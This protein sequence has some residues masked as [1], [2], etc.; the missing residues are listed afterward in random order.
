MTEIFIAENL[1]F[2]S[3]VDKAVKLAFMNPNSNTL[4]PLIHNNGVID[5]LKQI[6]VVAID[7][8]DKA[9]SNKLI[10]R[11]HGVTK[12]AYEKAKLKGFEIIDATCPKVREVYDIIENFDS[13][14]YLVAIIGNKDHPEIIGLASRVDGA[15]IVN[16]IEEVK[17][18]KK[19]DKIC[20]VSQTTNSKEKF[21]LISDKLKEKCNKIEIFNTIC[22]AT[23]RRQDSVK[24]V[25]K[26]VDFMIVI[27]G[28]HSANTKQLFNICSKYCNSVHIEE[29][30]EL[31][32]FSKY[33][34]IGITAG[35]STP[36][37]IINEVIE[38]IKC[39]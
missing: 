4:G 2:C 9:T 15:L 37:W 36:D 33:N 24:N 7:D 17:K 38:K 12:Q 19:H 18:L 13:R 3:G 6:N 32:D 5:K 30:D 35:A 25:A 21:D 14:G 29:A 1:G 34:K 26:K 31:T 27:G 10:L 22:D 28:K 16:S 23:R 11:A 39:L 20:V 8:L